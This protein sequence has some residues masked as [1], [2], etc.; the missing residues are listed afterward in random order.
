M[1]GRKSHIAAWCLLALTAVCCLS[2]AVGVSYAR[3][4]EDAGG[5][6][7]LGVR[8]NAQVYL[9]AGKDPEN[10]T[11]GAAAWEGNGT[12]QTMQFLIT[13]TGKDGKIPE[14]DQ[15]CTLRMA[16]SLDV[17]DGVAPMNVQLTYTKDDHA[18]ILQGQISRIEQDTVLY[19]QFGDGWLI[20]FADRWDNEMVWKLEGGQRSHLTM[21]LKLETDRAVEDGMIQLLLEGQMLPEA[22]Q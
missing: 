6:L 8:K 19:R 2:L 18:Q 3:Y 5:S 15:R 9:L 4:R 21:E 1:T 7:E 12:S 14:S 10:Y 20:T 16:A 22:G 13:N 11:P 17:W